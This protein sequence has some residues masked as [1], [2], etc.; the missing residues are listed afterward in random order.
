MARWEESF[1]GILTA[2]DAN[3]TIIWASY[4]FRSSKD[5]QVSEEISESSFH[6]VGRI[7]SY[8]CIFDSPF[9]QSQMCFLSSTIVPVG[10]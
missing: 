9:R 2:R 8:G 3:I 10:Q 7:K 1:Y 6:F 5:R 4:K